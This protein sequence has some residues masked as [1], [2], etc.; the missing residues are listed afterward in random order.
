M[1]KFVMLFKCTFICE[2]HTAV[3]AERSTTLVLQIQVASGCLGPRLES[4]P[5]L[6]YWLLKTIEK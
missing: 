5:G 2:T 4:H 1:P 6:Q 3:V